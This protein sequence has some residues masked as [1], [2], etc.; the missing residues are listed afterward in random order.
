MPPQSHMATLRPKTAHQH[1][2]VKETNKKLRLSSK[3]HH[4]C[5]FCSSLIRTLSRS[6]F[7]TIG[8]LSGSGQGCSTI[9]WLT[10]GCEVNNISATTNGSSIFIFETD[11]TDATLPRSGFLSNVSGSINP[12]TTG[13]WALGGLWKFLRNT[14]ARKEFRTRR[15]YRRTLPSSTDDD[16]LQL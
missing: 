8:R 9:R 12:P 2:K 4:N 1:D 15:H 3:P 7:C 16:E 6:K 13:H 14:T 5:F 11:I 10:T